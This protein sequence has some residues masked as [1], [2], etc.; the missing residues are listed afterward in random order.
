MLLERLKFQYIFKNTTLLYFTIDGLLKQANKFEIIEEDVLNENIDMSKGIYARQYIHL[1]IGRTSPKL[2]CRTNKFLYNNALKKL[3]SYDGGY[4]IYEDKISRENQA[5]F[6]AKQLSDAKNNINW[7]KKVMFYTSEPIKQN[8]KRWN[9]EIGGYWLKIGSLTDISKLRE[10]E[11][12]IA[13]NDVRNIVGTKV[14]NDAAIIENDEKYTKRVN[15]SFS[16]F[17]YDLCSE[18]LRTGK[19]WSIIEKYYK[20]WLTPEDFKNRGGIIQRGLDKAI[21]KLYRLDDNSTSIFYFQIYKVLDFLNIKKEEY[22]NYL[23]YDFKD[24]V[25]LSDDNSKLDFTYYKSKKDMTMRLNKISKSKRR[26]WMSDDEWLNMCNT[27]YEQM[28]C[29]I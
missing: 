19:V 13:L 25:R 12:M 20:K 1:D 6:N 11:R 9:E 2:H 10:Y 16:Y 28:L 18:S 3:N 27:K 15:K 14:K 7:D 23:P 29:K 22:I 8:S 21:E 26:H 24:F 5:I 4:I 17:D